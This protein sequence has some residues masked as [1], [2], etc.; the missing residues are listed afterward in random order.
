MREVLNTIKRNHR[1]NFKA[2]LFYLNLQAFE[3]AKLYEEIEFLRRDS[4]SVYGQD[5]S[6]YT[7]D[8]NIT[9]LQV[10]LDEKYIYEVEKA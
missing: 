4:P 10:E 7:W 1:D 6:V 2:P 8:G 3:Q 9:G 5:V